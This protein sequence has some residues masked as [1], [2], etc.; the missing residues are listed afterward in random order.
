MN[1]LP[2]YPTII[3]RHRKENL[4]KCS[5]RG[6]ESRPDFQFMTY[7][8]TE[9]PPLKDYLVLAVGAPPLTLEDSK[10][11]LFLVDATWRYA[12][13]MLKKLEP[14]VD[15]AQYRSFPSP[16]QT[17]YPR[18]QEDCPNPDQGLA[19]IEALYAA[20]RLLGWNST[21]LLDGYYWKDQFL[22]KNPILH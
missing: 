7:P 17:A 20:Y 9:L 3:L 15:P 21:G 12:A 18:R 1:S 4:K 8:F 5:L 14:H 11:G 2:P 10:K 22:A 6:L 13:Q 19:S 16:I